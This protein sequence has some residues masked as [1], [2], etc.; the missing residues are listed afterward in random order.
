LAGLVHDV[1][2]VVVASVTQFHRVGAAF[3]IAVVA[4]QAGAAVCSIAVPVEAVELRIG[5]VTV[6]CAGR[7]SVTV[8]IELVVGNTVV[9]VVVQAVAHLDLEWKPRRVAVVA[10]A[11]A[12]GESIPVHI[13]VLQVCAGIVAV[14]G[15]ECPAVLIE[16]ELG[17]GD[18][19]IAVVVGAVADL[20]RT[21]EDGRSLVV[22][23]AMIELAGAGRPSVVVF[24][25]SVDFQRRRTDRLW[26]RV[27]TDR[28][29]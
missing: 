15:A 14:S 13:V 17:G 22:A 29:G 1:I 11:V 24:V 28:T 25:E 8:D 10:V 23:V 26:W 20:G 16:V 2:A 5:V 9:A 21:R 27:P 6:T 19:T 18:D 12:R 7:L 3:R 4:I